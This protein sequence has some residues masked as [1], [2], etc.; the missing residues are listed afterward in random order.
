MS[1][2]HWTITKDH[3]RDP[4]HDRDDA[5]THGPSGATLTADQ[6]AANPKALEFR[7]C[8][9]DGELYYTGKY[10]GPDDETL[11]A[12]LDDFGTPNAGCTSIHYKNA[13]GAWEQL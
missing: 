5:G 4:E 1:N 13:Q 6:I 2:Y 9:D 8:D 3:I 12:P 11:F 7:M 10:L